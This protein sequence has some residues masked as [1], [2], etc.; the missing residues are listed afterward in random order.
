MHR[1]RMIDVSPRL[2]FP[3]DRRVTPVDY[4]IQQLCQKYTRL[5][6][7]FEHLVSI[8]QNHGNELIIASIGTNVKRFVLVWVAD[9]RLRTIRALIAAKA[10]M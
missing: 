2:T 6:Q 7:I 8:L 3:D 9:K 1:S 5:L 4:K 10:W